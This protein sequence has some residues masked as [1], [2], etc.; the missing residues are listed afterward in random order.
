MRISETKTRLFER[1]SKIDTA[2]VTSSGQK[3][4]RLKF[5]KLEMNSSEIQ[6]IITESENLCCNKVE[7]PT[8]LDQFLNTYDPAKLN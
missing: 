7:N 8:V 6:M 4:K 1:I 5:V 3:Q 2:L